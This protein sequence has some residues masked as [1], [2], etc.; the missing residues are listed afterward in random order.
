[1]NDISSLFQFNVVELP[2]MSC[3]WAGLSFESTLLATTAGPLA[4]AVLLGLPLFYC[5]YDVVNGCRMTY[6]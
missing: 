3:L 2:K 5:W 1:M 4:I 6:S